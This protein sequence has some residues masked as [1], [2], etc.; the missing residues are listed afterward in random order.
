MTGRWIAL[1][2]IIVFGWGALELML[3]QMK[4]GEHAVSPQHFE[5]PEGT[6][7]I[8]GGGKGTLTFVAAP[9]LK[10]GQF[11]LKC[12]D[13]DR[14]LTL[15]RDEVSEP[16][17]GVQ[18]KLWQL[19]GGRAAVEVTWGEIVEPGVEP[20]ADAAAPGSPAPTATEPAGDPEPS[21]DAEQP[22]PDPTSK[23]EPKSEPTPEPSP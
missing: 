20:G 7:V 9:F 8:V 1:V 12:K 11:R 17:C 10:N 15:R 16:I 21:V 6:T 18:V 3:R 13:D 5:L 19:M 4:I 14:N 22:D 2:V 23:S